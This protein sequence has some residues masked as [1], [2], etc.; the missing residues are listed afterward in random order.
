MTTEEASERAEDEEAGGDARAGDAQDDS[1]DED[2][3]GD[4]GVAHA[5]AEKDEEED[6]FVKP[7]R[8]RRQK[9][10]IFGTVEHYAIRLEYQGRGKAHYHVPQLF[11][12]VRWP[13][14]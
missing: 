3:R 5:A 11:H 12:S 6:A 1:E 10:G 2:A 7:R 9:R 4:A 14:R 8:Q 13:P